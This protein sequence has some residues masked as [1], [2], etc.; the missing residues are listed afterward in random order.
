M[1]VEVNDSG[2]RD[3]DFEILIHRQIFRGAV[4]S[5][6]YFVAGVKSVVETAECLPVVAAK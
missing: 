3:E 6:D 1:R 4:R 2:A 5:L